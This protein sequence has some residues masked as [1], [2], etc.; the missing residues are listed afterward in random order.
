LQ[1]PTAFG[2]LERNSV[3][4]TKPNRFRSSTLKK[5]NEGHEWVDPNFIRDDPWKKL[6][7]SERKKAERNLYILYGVMIVF[8]VLP[9][10][11]FYFFLRRS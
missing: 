3:L 6:S 5:K 10:I 4:L 7:E 11:L 9:F 2:Y 1:T 8:A